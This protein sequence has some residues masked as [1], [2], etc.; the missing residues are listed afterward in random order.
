ML[1]TLHSHTENGVLSVEVPQFNLNYS[2]DPLKIQD[3]EKNIDN[4]FIRASVLTVLTYPPTKE[5]I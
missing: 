5:L 3:I 2:L 4:P 1:F